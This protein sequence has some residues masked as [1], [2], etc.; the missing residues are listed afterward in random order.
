MNNAVKAGL[1]LFAS[2]ALVSCGSS[3][4]TDTRPAPT[5]PVQDP[6]ANQYFA[7]SGYSISREEL[8]DSEVLDTSFWSKGLVNDQDPDIHIA[9]N[10][11]TGGAN[12]LN[13]GSAAY[14]TPEDVFI[15]DGVLYLR[16]RKHPDGYEG[17]DPAGTYQYTCGWIQSRGKAAYN[18]TERGLYVEIYA[19]FPRGGNLWPAIWMVPN[20]QMWPPEIDIWEYFGTF[21]Q[22]NWGEDIMKMNYFSGDNWTVTER[23]Q[24][25]MDAFATTYNQPIDWHA[26]GFLW[27]A[28]R[29]VWSIDGAEVHTLE[30]GVDV[31]DAEWPDEPMA[32]VFN[33]GVQTYDPDR[34]PNAWLAQEDAESY[35]PNFVEIDYF[36]IFEQDQN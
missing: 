17:T 7:P 9:W 1:L 18:G 10:P 29:M 11:R 34:E 20:R 15:E 16:N 5:P 25:R 35:W 30:R 21:W 13:D 4:T 14:H 23:Y 19:R 28:D 36:V 8:F 22:P 6:P 27:D 26:F 32:F 12:L 24:G 2:A 33:N 31:P 3:S